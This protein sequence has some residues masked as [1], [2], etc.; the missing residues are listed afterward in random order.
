MWG[1]SADMDAI[2]EVCRRKGLLLI[3][4]FSHAFFLMHNDE[5]VGSFGD[6]SYA[7]MQRKKTFS[8]GEGGIIVTRSEDIYRSSPGTWCTTSSCDSSTW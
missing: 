4:D 5:V 6:V 1:I 2:V 3:E 8:V 7:S